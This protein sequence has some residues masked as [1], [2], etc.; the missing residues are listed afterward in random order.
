MRR[1]FDG[2]YRIFQSS[3]TSSISGLTITNGRTPDGVTED[4]A[5]NGGGILQTGSSLTL[6]DVVVTGNS[7]GNGGP[8]RFGSPNLD[9]FGGG[10]YASG[11]LTMTDCVISNNTTGNG[12]TGLQSGGRAATSVALQYVTCR[13]PRR[14]FLS[15]RLK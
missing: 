5:P 14:P 9:G 11:T 3:G 15:N 6:R 4:V 7:T 2:F 12:G 10:S 8:M 1:D 13:S